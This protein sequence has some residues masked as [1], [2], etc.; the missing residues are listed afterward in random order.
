MLHAD[1]TVTHALTADAVSFARDLAAEPS[2]SRALQFA[3]THDIAQLAAEWRAFEQY[4]DCTVFQSYDWLATWQAHIGTLTKTVPAIVTARRPSGELAFI[5]P[6]AVQPGRLAR[7]LVFLGRDLGDYNAPLLAPDFAR[8]NVG[9]P[10]LWTR[11]CADLQRDPRSRH[12]LV[13]LDKMPVRVGTQ[14]NPMA[15][16]DVAPNPSGAYLTALTADWDTFFGAK[17]NSSARKRDRNKRRRLD[18]IGEIRMVTATETSDAAQTLSI[19]MEQKSQALTRMGVPDIF[20]RAGYRDFFQALATSPQ[21]RGLTHISRLEVGST[22]AATNL[23]LTFRGIYY[24]V[25]ASYDDG[26]TSRYGAGALHLQELLQ[27]AVTHGFETFDFTI[28]DEPYKRQWCDVELQLHDYVAAASLR[29]H[30]IAAALSAWRRTKRAIKQS[31]VLWPKV[32]RLRAAFGAK[33]R[34]AE[35]QAAPTDDAGRPG[36]DR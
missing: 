31:P 5:L 22:P 29:G 19:L 8:L 32:Q 27:H 1:N 12:D 33:A 9:F 36:E 35:Q 26:P 21:T 4:A 30:M 7:R 13:M 11:I 2:A 16:L 6:L 18:E 14:A 17:R 15:S 28:G 23:G 20:A 3:V 24:H 10:A 25:L 34:T